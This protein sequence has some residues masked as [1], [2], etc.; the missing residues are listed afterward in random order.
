MVSQEQRDS[1]QQQAVKVDEQ[2]AV[3]SQSVQDASE[4]SSKDGDVYID[5]PVGTGKKRRKRRFRERL[6]YES[7]ISPKPSIWP[8]AL[9]FAVAITL[10]GLI[11]N[12]YFLVIGVVLVFVCITGWVL[13]HQKT[14][15]DR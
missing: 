7:E 14:D 2:E 3:D 15:T 9:A 8:L 5:V 10:F 6:V 1:V 12:V 4:G 13:E 11:Y